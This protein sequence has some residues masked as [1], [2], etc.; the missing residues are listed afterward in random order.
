ML[1]I[2][3]KIIYSSLTKHV[4]NVAHLLK[5]KSPDPTHGFTK[6]LYKTEF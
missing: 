4:F 5:F 3:K 6:N 2:T 1:D